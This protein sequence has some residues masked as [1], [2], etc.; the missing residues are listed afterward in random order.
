MRASKLIVAILLASSLICGTWTTL[1]P[2]A[3]AQLPGGW[4]EAPSPPYLASA[5]YLTAFPEGSCMARAAFLAFNDTITVQ[6]ID[7]GSLTPA[8]ASGEL[9]SGLAAIA[10]WARKGSPPTWASWGLMSMLYESYGQYSP[11]GDIL[12]HSSPL[13]LPGLGLGSLG[14]SPFSDLRAYTGKQDPMFSPGL[15][16]GLWLALVFVGLASEEG[17]FRGKAT[18]LAYQVSRAYGVEMWLYANITIPLDTYHEQEGNYRG[19][20]GQQ[21][22]NYLAFLFIY[23]A[24]VC[25]DRLSEIQGS[26]LSGLPS[27]TPCDLLQNRTRLGEAP[28]ALLAYVALD[29]G[30]FYFAYG[31]E[32]PEAPRLGGWLTLWASTLFF[33]DA[34][35]THVE[36]YV[37]QLSLNSAFGHEGP[38]CSGGSEGQETLTLLAVE[39]PWT[40]VLSAKPEG[41]EVISYSPVDAIVLLNMTTGDCIE[42]L[43]VTYEYVREFPSLLVVQQADSYVAEPGDEVE[44]SVIIQN[45]GSATA[46]NVTCLT[47]SEDIYS[48]ELSNL[49]LNPG[50]S[51]TF[52]Y[53]AVVESWGEDYR[54]PGYYGG[55]Y[56]SYGLVPPVMAI[57][58]SSP[59]YNTTSPY[60]EGPEL[61][62]VVWSNGLQFV[63]P[64]EPGPSLLA[65][66]RLDNYTVSQGED[67]KATLEVWNVG[68]AGAEDIDVFLSWY[69]FWAP[70]Y[71]WTY[72][73][74]DVE[75]SWFFSAHIDELGPGEHVELTFNIT[76]QMPGYMVVYAEVVSERGAMR[77]WSNTATLIAVPEPNMSA[78]LPYV[79]VE[80]YVSPE[81]EVREGD[82]L[83]VLL[84]VSNVG[85]ATAEDVLIVDDVPEGLERVGSVKISPPDKPFEDHSTASQVAIVISSL[86]PG[87]V[88]KVSYD[89][90]AVRAGTYVFSSAE[91]SYGYYGLSTRGASGL[92]LITVRPRGPGPTPKGLGPFGSLITPIALLA[93]SIVATG[94]VVALYARRRH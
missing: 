21:E 25:P 16:P 68:S 83:T 44:V 42:D 63:R 81:G 37:F 90:R 75:E 12:D 53:T 72:A 3:Y 85:T 93:A 47:S 58:F 19:F 35:V 52:S 51:F 18:Y 46:Y 40:R 31:G 11:F 29:I 79:I 86:E 10:L 77:V 15:S 9:P 7:L 84:V 62:F 22:G 60:W 88:V 66:L 24:D 59:I 73:W 70:T 32:E 30:L 36:D 6:G 38:I 89:V 27:G 57:Y 13:P 17:Y 78:G 43:I 61:P 2:V 67:A 45:V 64:G 76:T 55:S 65:F 48:L 39:V 33:L 71:W 1:V 87:E 34:H 4:D 50:E 49:Q 91:G 92:A 20:S 80:K 56:T 54:Y 69:V 14:P 82:V 5:I 74:P 8:S 94:I 28:Y 23:Y 26:F 41:T